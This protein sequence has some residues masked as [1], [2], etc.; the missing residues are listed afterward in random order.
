MSI[1]L[2]FSHRPHPNKLDE[3]TGPCILRSISRLAAPKR[4][5]GV[6][7]QFS[8][9]VAWMSHDVVL[10]QESVQEDHRNTRRELVNNINVTLFRHKEHVEH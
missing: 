8:G 1:T 2:T 4:R 6:S 9:D 3:E 5:D 7:F 10:T